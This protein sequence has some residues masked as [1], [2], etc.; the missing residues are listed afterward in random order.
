[1]NQWGG[2]HWKQWRK[3]IEQALL[4]HQRMEDPE[5]NFYGSW[6]PVGPWGEDGGRVYSTAVGAL[7]LE[8]YYRYG[9]VLG[10]RG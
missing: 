5:D 2:E 8:V 6:D 3:S 9:H 4:P 1:M 10:S 7:I